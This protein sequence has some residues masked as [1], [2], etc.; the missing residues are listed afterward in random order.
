MCVTFVLVG[1]TMGWGI[2]MAMGSDCRVQLMPSLQWM[3]MLL[4]GKCFLMTSLECLC[5]VS[6]IPGTRYRT[7]SMYMVDVVVH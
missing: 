4:G 1:I 3:A 2:T 6:V 7:H 5:T